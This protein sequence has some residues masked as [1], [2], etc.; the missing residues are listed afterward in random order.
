[1]NVADKLG[2]ASL[3]FGIGSTHACPERR[4]LLVC[5]FD[6]NTGCIRSERAALCCPQCPPAVPSEGERGS[7]SGST[8]NG[9]TAIFPFILQAATE[10]SD[11][12]RENETRPAGHCPA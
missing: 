3:A 1:M 5:I 11:G 7:S 12:L 10:T 8:H 4:A 9:K 2:K 6:Y